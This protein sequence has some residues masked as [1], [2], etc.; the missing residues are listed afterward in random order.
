VVVLALGVSC[1]KGTGP[2]PPEPPSS[3]I[4]ELGL[5]QL[6]PYQDST[7][8]NP[9]RIAVLLEIPYADASAIDEAT[10]VAR[11]QETLKS[12]FEGDFSLFNT[13]P[14]SDYQDRFQVYYGTMLQSPDPGYTPIDTP[15]LEQLQASAQAQSGPF[16]AAT[17]AQE[18]RGILETIYR[19]S[20]IGPD[21]VQGFFYP[22]DALWLNQ[23]IDLLDQIPEEAITNPPDQYS[24]AEKAWIVKKNILRYQAVF[25]QQANLD[26]QI[27]ITDDAFGGAQGY[28][29]N[30]TLAGMPDRIFMNRTHPIFSSVV[31]DFAGRTLVHEM[32]H[33][34]GWFTDEYYPFDA[35]DDLSA[36]VDCNCVS[37]GA[38]GPDGQTIDPKTDNPWLQDQLS[39]EMPDKSLNWSLLSGP[40]PGYDGSLFPGCDGSYRSYRTHEK[41]IMSFHYFSMNAAD[42]QQG[43]GPVHRYYMEE[44]FLKP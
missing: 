18:L 32:G 12:I 24:E 40:V 29:H 31:N 43:F 20:G 4:S 5:G 17:T 41:S 38:V 27:I 42:F 44:L 34:A 36:K 1:T 8:P 10:A 7:D 39:V 28:A 35:S 33:I 19:N 15:A 11:V 25:D 26:V 16:R 13:P 2:T 3:P 21:Q 6:L 14:F 9:L 37:D 22:L 30:T 23:S